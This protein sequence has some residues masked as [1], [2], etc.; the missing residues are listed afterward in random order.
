MKTNENG[1]ATTPNLWDSVSSIKREVNRNTI[2]PQETRG[3]SQPKSINNLILHL[4]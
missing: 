3:A 4:K 1:N 2:L